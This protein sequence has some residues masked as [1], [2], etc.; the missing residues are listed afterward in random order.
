MDV[1]VLSGARA[2]LVWTT[3]AQSSAIVILPSQLSLWRLV[4]VFVS[5]TRRAST[6]LDAIAV[7]W[8]F[9][10]MVQY[11]KVENIER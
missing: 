6:S 9:E 5:A 1:F 8:V 2:F 11:D 10:W 4:N 3:L 7:R